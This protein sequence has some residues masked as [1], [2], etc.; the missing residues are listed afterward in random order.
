MR[1]DALRCTARNGE[2]R[3]V[4]N[5]GENKSKD[6]VDAEE[7]PGKLFAP[8]RERTADGNDGENKIERFG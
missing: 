2:R 1:N 4:K 3:T 6:L 7:K 8:Q 5:D